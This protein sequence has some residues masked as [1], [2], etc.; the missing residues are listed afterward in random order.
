MRVVT[1]AYELA[2]EESVSGCF[3]VTE[4]HCGQSLGFSSRWGATLASWDRAAAHTTFIEH[5]LA[6][7]ITGADLSQGVHRISCIPRSS[8]SFTAIAS[9]DLILIMATKHKVPP[10]LWTILCILL[11]ALGGTS[12]AKR[13]GATFLALRLIFVIVLSVLAVREWWKYQHRSQWNNMEE[14]A[15]HNL[16]RR[17]RRWAT[18]EHETPQR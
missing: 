1:R 4:C 14:D 13:L 16:L 9:N 3:L 18:D 12:Y 17:L 15:A 10:I 2:L 8:Y 6:S 5:H 11:L 7:G